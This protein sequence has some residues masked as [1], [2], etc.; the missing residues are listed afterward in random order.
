MFQ[1]DLLLDFV[2]YGLPYCL[3]PVSPWRSLPCSHLRFCSYSSLFY[4][5]FSRCPIRFS[6][7]LFSIARWGSHVDPFTFQLQWPPLENICTI[8]L[9][10][11]V[12]PVPTWGYT[13][14]I[15]TSS[16]HFDLSTYSE[17]CKVLG[18]L[19]VSRVFVL[20]K[21]D[22]PIR[23]RS[24]P[25]LSFFCSVPGSLCS[26]WGG[27]IRSPICSYFSGNCAIRLPTRPSSLW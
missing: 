7:C 26:P 22:L 24:A 13:Y 10:L 18:C 9:P 17:P 27:T 3:V 19:E 14:N 11:I 23:W 20:S 16:E 6:C 1:V 4:S 15:D 8:F 2:G 25:S 5:S 21:K 12:L